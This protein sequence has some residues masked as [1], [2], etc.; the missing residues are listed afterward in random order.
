V[1]KLVLLSLILLT[2]T[3]S[4]QYWPINDYS[5]HWIRIR[6]NPNPQPNVYRWEVS[7]GVSVNELNKVGLLDMG[8]GRYDYGYFE[9]FGE[10][11]YSMLNGPVL[12]FPPSLMDYNSTITYPNPNQFISP[13]F[14]GSAFC[15]CDCVAPTPDT[16]FPADAFGF[17]MEDP[18]A[19]WNIW[20]INHG[21]TH[22]TNHM[23]T[24]IKIPCP[25]APAFYKPNDPLF[26]TDSTYIPLPDG[27][28]LSGD[29]HL[30]SYGCNP[31]RGSSQP[32]R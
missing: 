9:F 14:V 20:A 12:D 4:A 15:N 17:W 27:V 24:W 30:L 25:P 28:V 7:G 8:S 18:K 29:S 22:W 3:A 31:P 23:E 19:P 10:S 6:E 32:K 5:G 13:Q 16:S 1:K 11:E 21:Y 2:A 26:F